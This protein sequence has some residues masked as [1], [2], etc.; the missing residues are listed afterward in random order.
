MSKKRFALR[1][2]VSVLSLL[3]VGCA[4]DVEDVERAAL[5]SHAWGKYHWARTSNPFTIKL[6]NNVS[7]AWAEHLSVAASDWSRSSVLDATVAAGG[8]G[9]RCRPTSGRAEVCNARYGANGWLGLAS[10]WADGEHITQGTVRLNDTYFDTARYNTPAWRASVTCQEIGHLFGLA[11]NDEDFST[12][13]G[14]CMDYS[15]DPGQ[16]QHPNQHDYTQLE[17]IY[18]HLDS[19]TTVGAAGAAPPALAGVD[20]T[21]MEHWGDP[22]DVSPSGRV[23]TFV[24][25]LGHLQV[26]TTVTWAPE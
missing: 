8:G 20:P 3:H 11:H 2:S 1:L 14:T 10:V 25:D 9:R 4:A 19:M 21:D 23:H 24:R 7:S 12:T 6:G 26:I 15:N 16:N 13:T 17:A 22:V 18:K 5:A